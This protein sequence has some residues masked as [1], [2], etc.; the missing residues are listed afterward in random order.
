MLSIFKVRALFFLEILCFKLGFHC[1]CVQ[2][3][4]EQNGASKF[5]RHF[6]AYT[7]FALLSKN[8]PPVCIVSTSTYVFGNVTVTQ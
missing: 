4:F 3:I 7:N 1:L 5:W 8:Q 2:E 6:D